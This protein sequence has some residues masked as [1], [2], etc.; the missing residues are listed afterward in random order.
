MM[1]PARFKSVELLHPIAS[2]DVESFDAR[3]TQPFAAQRAKAPFD[4]FDLSYLIEVNTTQGFHRKTFIS[5][6]YEAGK[7]AR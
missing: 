6:F 5:H 1:I 3:F 2:G 4:L 7:N